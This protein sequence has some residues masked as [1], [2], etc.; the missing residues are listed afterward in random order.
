MGKFPSLLP[1]VVACPTYGDACHIQVINSLLQRA[2][3]ERN[4]YTALKALFSESTEIS[5]LL[6]RYDKWYA[7]RI[8]KE[9]GN[10]VVFHWYV[11]VFSFLRVALIISL[12]MKLSTI[13][14]TMGSSGGSTLHG[15]RSST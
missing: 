13:R 11:R 3:M 14:S 6:T 15:R 5:E 4:N 9:T 10:R 7:F 8:G 2:A 1:I 12:G